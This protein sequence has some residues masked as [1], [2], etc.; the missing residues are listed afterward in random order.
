M[1]KRVSAAQAKAQLSA[2]SADVAH[3]G[4]RVVIE[5][6]GTPMVALVSLADLDLL[7][8]DSSNFGAAAR[9]PCPRGRLAGS[10]R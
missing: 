2:L 9:G 10:G 8:Q 1:V 5:R 4:Q 7:G 3:G 6:H